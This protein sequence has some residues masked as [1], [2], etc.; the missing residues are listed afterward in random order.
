M[1]GMKAN[2]VNSRRVTTVH[3]LLAGSK[4]KVKGTGNQIQYGTALV[5]KSTLRINGS[6]NIIVLGDRSR[7]AGVKITIQGDNHTL[8]IGPDVRMNNLE[9]AFEDSGCEISIGEAT[10]IDGGHVAAAEPGSRIT[11]GSGC[12]FSRGIHIVTTDSH[13]ILDQETRDRINPA[14]DVEIGDHV[15][16]GSFAKILKGA[17]LHSGCIIGL[18][19]VVTGVVDSNTVVAGNPSRVVK[20]NVDWSRAR[21]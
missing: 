8:V 7:L 20:R 6:D 10:T 3:N 19:A 4:K 15:W 5:K 13:S 16:V 9:I 11:I 14:R 12:M 17:V 18:G 21:I 2:L 1:S